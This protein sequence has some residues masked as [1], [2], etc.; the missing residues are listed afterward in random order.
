MDEELVDLE[1][2]IRRWC[3]DTFGA[4]SDVGPFSFACW[5]D[6]GHLGVLGLDTSEGG[7]SLVHVARAM[8]ILGHFGCRGPLVPTFVATHLLGGAQRARVLE[9][10]EIAA[11]NFGDRVTP[12][13][14]VAS[15]HIQIDPIE[16]QAWLCKTTCEPI[17]TPSMSGEPWA[18]VELD[19]VAPLGDARSAI[20]VGLVA[21]ASYL[22][23]AA[24][25]MVTEAANYAADRRQFG[26]PIGNFQAIS[27][28]LADSWA[29]LSA[30]RVQIDDIA[31]GTPTMDRAA[32]S[33]V[34]AARHANQAVYRAYQTYGG[35]GF[36][37]E[38]H[39]ASL[40][41]RVR[42]VAV[43]GPSAAVVER[44]ALRTWYP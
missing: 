38:N 37:T 17:P 3:T 36:A 8:E 4:G 27:H 25:R 12:W 32:R 43:I 19:R 29:R 42:E 26:V 20:V 14:E 18:S 9:G 35:M 31:R 10:A 21:Q 40:G 28:G 15:I 30:A 33:Q 1:S 6:L 41:L 34:A 23:G 13:S 11:I 22:V 7:G 44:E 39:V 5:K 16:W 2:V 24:L